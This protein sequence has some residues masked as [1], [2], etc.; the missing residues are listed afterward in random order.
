MSKII[1]K[2]NYILFDYSDLAYLQNNQNYLD[3]LNQMVEFEKLNFNQTTP[4]Y[5]KNNIRIYPYEYKTE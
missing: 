1:Q 4:L 2:S 3:Q 5:N